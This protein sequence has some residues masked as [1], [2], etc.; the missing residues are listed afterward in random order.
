MPDTLTPEL[1]RAVVQDVLKL[2]KEKYVYPDVG[3][4]IADAIQAKLDRGDYG[5]ITDAHELAATLTMDLRDVS[6]D[7]HWAVMYSPTQ[8]TAYIDPET[9]EDETQLARWLERARRDNFGFEKI[10]RL[11]GNIGYIDL[12]QFAPAEY[13]GNTAVA[14]MNFVANCDAL[15][16]DLR[17]NHG[18]H[19]S[20]VQLI[21]SYLIKPEPKHINTFYN[22]P[23]D[24]YQQFW[25][26]PHV[27]GTRMPDIPV[28]VLTSHATGSG[29]EEFAYDLKYMER[30]TLIG[31]ITV[32]AAHPVDREIVQE[33]FYVLLPSGRPVNPITSEN[34]EG[35]GVEPHIS[36]PQEDALKTAHLLAFEQQIERCQGDVQKRDLE[37]GREI[38]TS[39]YEPISVAES[40][41][42][43][44]AGQYGERTFTLE[45]GSLMYSH[46]KH[47]ATWRLIPITE[48]RFRLDEDLKFEFILDAYGEV[49]SLVVTYRDGRPEVSVARTE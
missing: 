9:E 39:L 37:W 5:S 23:T 46:Q 13:A 40:T 11:K 12:R 7:R 19:P 16:F 1:C 27:P 3:E 41:L 42:S 29:A 24:D 17:Q 44:Y 33:H 31:E 2:A 49:E 32:G 14:A 22:R 35:K 4:Q 45:D 26:F 15:I 47:P 36:V 43:R 21:I 30:A 48:T 6:K 25:T 20:M 18:G 8:E 28:Y 34:W 38:L 10:E